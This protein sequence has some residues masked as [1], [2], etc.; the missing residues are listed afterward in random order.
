MCSDS[1]LAVGQQRALRPAVHVLDLGAVF[2]VADA[3]DRVVFD[4]PIERRRAAAASDVPSSSYRVAVPIREP[5]AEVHEV[6]KA[7]STAAPFRR[8]RSSNFRA[9]RRGQLEIHPTIVDIP[10][11]H[12]HEQ[13][14]RQ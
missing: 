3:V 11:Q 1:M 8:L 6:S 14:T 5:L 4:D 13:G 9:T 2:V 12:Q 7:W 10:F